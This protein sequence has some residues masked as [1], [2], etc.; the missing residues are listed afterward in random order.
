M[1][2]GFHR[3]I[4]VASISRIT[5]T[6]HKKVDKYSNGKSI[7]TPSHE[8][9]PTIEEPRFQWKMQKIGNRSNNEQLIMKNNFQKYNF[10]IVLML[11]R[12]D[13]RG[14]INERSVVGGEE[15]YS[16]S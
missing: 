6:K 11:V 13:P 4:K 16:V 15:Y 14:R 2:D 5:R 1:L 3:A 10:A 12:V 8:I 9:E 7:K